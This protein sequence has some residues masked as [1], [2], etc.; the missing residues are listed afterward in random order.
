MKILILHGPNMNLFGIRSSKEGKKITLDKINRHIRRYI[1]DKNLETKI[2]QTHRSPLETIP[3]YCS[4]VST[5]A[6]PLS[7]KSFAKNLGKHWEEKLSRALKHCMHVSDNHP[8]QFLDLNYKKLI[9]EP[10]DEMEVIYNF[11]DK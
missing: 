9:S 1:R 7:N 2:I 11:L 8:N 4:M 6:E 3:S 10:I 5:L